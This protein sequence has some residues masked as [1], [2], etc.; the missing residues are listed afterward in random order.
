M[1]DVSPVKHFHQ[2]FSLSVSEELPTLVW[3]V[4][5]LVSTVR[6]K[7]YAK[8]IETLTKSGE[9][10]AKNSEESIEGRV[11]MFHYN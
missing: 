2:L 5:E 10:E 11:A 7:Y 9:C 4:I 6:I 1:N 8:W 3:I